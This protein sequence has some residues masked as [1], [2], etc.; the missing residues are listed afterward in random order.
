MRYIIDYYIYLL[1]LYRSSLP[2]TKL[3]Y[4]PFTIDKTLLGSRT[5]C[6]KYAAYTTLNRRKHPTLINADMPLKANAE[7]T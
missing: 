2:I 6:L 1:K 3:I 4:I 5:F 7:Y